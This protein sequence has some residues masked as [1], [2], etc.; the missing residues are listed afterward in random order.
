[1]YICIN[2]FP[3]I[4][5]VC[6]LASCRTSACC[7]QVWLRATAGRLQEMCEKPEA[8]LPL[9]W[10]RLWV[11]LPGRIQGRSACCALVLFRSA[12]YP[13]PPQRCSEHHLC[14]LLVPPSLLHI[15]FC[16]RV[17]TTLLQPLVVVDIRNPACSQ[18]G[19][20]HTAAVSSTA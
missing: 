16:A 17:R 10:E 13:H 12:L 5:F 3:F 19:S 14:C 1:M 18:N 7:T 4:P 15:C 2:T 11:L 8:G 9:G 20:H 6:F